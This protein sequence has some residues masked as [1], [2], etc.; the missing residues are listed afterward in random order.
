VKENAEARRKEE[1]FTRAANEQQIEMAENERR[2]EE[3]TT[4]GELE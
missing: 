2:T 3:K 4:L 1:H